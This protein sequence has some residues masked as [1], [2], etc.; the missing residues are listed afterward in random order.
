MTRLAVVTLVH[1]RLQHLVQQHRFLAAAARPPEHYVVVAMADPEVAGW[2]PD[3]LPPDLV[4]IDADPARLP[5]AAAR[6]AG[7]ARALEAGA[8]VVVM[9]DVDCVPGSGLLDAYRDLVAA[10]PGSIWS[11]PVTYLTADQPVADLAGPQQLAAWSRPHPARA[12]VADG[13]DALP[14][15]LFWSLSFALSGDCWRRVGGFC[16]RYVGYGA[17]DTDFARLARRRGVGLGWCARAEA[18]HQ[19]HP[20]QTPPVQHLRAIVANTNLFHSR[21]GEFAMP[22]W[23]AEFERSGLIQLVDGRWRLVESP[24]VGGAEEVRHVRRRSAAGR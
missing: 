11:G 17:E 13:P 23:L 19:F 9:L 1:G 6:N 7:V 18:F 20:T 8:D 16:E 12:G 22:G 15:E 21:W 4:R 3:T 2:K 5:L 10:D 14:R 24:E